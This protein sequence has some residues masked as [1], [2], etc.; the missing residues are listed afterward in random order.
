MLT[1]QAKRSGM[2]SHFVS[3][4]SMVLGLM[5]GFR[6]NQAY[7]RYWEGRKQWSALFSHVR[8]IQRQVSLALDP[9]VRQALGGPVRTTTSTSSSSSSTSSEPDTT[10]S[11]EAKAAYL[12]IARLALAYAIALKHYLRLENGLFYADFLVLLDPASLQAMPQEHRHALEKA[13]YF[14]T[15]SERERSFILQALREIHDGPNAP[16]SNI[17]GNSSSPPLSASP[18]GDPSLCHTVNASLLG[19]DNLLPL[20]LIRQLYLRTLTAS[21]PPTSP[22]ASSPDQANTTVTA[23]SDGP[24]GPT[25]IAPLISQ[26]QALQEVFVTCERILTTPSPLVFKIYLKQ[27]ITLYIMALPMVLFP[28]LGW[29]F[30]PVMALSAFIFYGME[31]ISAEIENPFGYDRN[32]L[33]LDAYCD[34]MRYEFRELMQQADIYL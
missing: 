25:L 4:L 12:T 23:I 22:P 28:A 19:D 11:P 3:L 10:P 24:I 7:D 8:T 21:R 29:S 5:L 9:E 34:Q 20:L 14:R 13:G 2:A 26:V 6:S 18:L 1:N 32:D 33:P 16:T 17:G 30:V 31:G 27:I 15:D